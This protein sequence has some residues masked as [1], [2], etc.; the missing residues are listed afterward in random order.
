MQAIVSGDGLGRKETMGLQ[1]AGRA[2]RWTVA[3]E[4]LQWPQKP[5]NKG[6]AEK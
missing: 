4:E 1:R 6:E 3:A 5:I 2:T